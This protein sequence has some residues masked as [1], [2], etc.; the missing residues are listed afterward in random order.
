MIN[1]IKMN[2]SYFIVFLIVI[3]FSTLYINLKKKN[4]ENND[5]YNI[6]EEF[7]NKKL[8]E[9]LGVINRYIFEGIGQLN[10]SRE[11]KKFSQHNMDSNSIESRGHKIREAL[12]NNINKHFDNI[13]NHHLLLKE[14]TEEKYSNYV[15]NLHAFKDYYFNIKMYNTFDC[16]KIIIFYIF[17]YQLGVVFM[18][19][20]YLA[21]KMSE[22]SENL[23]ID[24]LNYSGDAIR[25]KVTTILNKLNILTDNIH[26]LVNSNELTTYRTLIDR[27]KENNNYIEEINDKII[28]IIK[29]DVVT[30]LNLYEKNGMKETT[31]NNI[32]TFNVILPTFKK[33]KEN[34]LND[35]DIDLIIYNEDRIRITNNIPPEYP[36]PVNNSNNN[37]NDEVIIDFIFNFFS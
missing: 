36:V 4:I 9:L 33:F 34:H 17:I 15:N 24:G 31:F 5:N 8:S 19:M 2:N 16:L 37:S 21:E 30:L 10:T 14:F 32:I 35:L 26:K 11:L 29:S 3:I 20:D 27:L 23:N 7:F 6:T 1:N 12:N 22:N 18:D 25:E 28:D 13:V